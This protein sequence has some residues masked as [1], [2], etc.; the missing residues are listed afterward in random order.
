MRLNDGP[1]IPSTAV[2]ELNGVPVADRVQRGA[3]RE[4]FLH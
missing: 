2:G 4:V 1:H 3:R